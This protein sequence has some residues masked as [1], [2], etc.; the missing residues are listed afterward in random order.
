MWANG[1]CDLEFGLQQQP[2]LFLVLLRMFEDGYCR[3]EVKLDYWEWVGI[4]NDMTWF[5]L[6]PPVFNVVAHVA[7]YCCIIFVDSIC[8][9]IEDW[10][11]GRGGGRYHTTR[12]T[13]D[14]KFCVCVIQEYFTSTD[15]A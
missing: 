10:G 12:S 1:L 7:C 13:A 14:N 11:G 2:N 3:R 15:S 5:P 8:V 9:N 4:S 6:P